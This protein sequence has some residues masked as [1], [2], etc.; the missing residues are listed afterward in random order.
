MLRV[1]AKDYIELG[2]QISAGRITFELD[3]CVEKDEHGTVKLTKIGVDTLRGDLAELLKVCDHLTLPI[4]KSLIS[5]RMSDPPRT[6]REFALLVEAVLEELKNLLFLFVPQHRA[7]YYELIL[8]S[9]VT[10]AFPVAA[11][12]IAAAGNCVAAAVY[13]ASVFHSMRA[14]EIGIQAMARALNVTF[15]YPLELAEWGKIVGEIEPKINDLKA[16]PRSTQRDEDL[17]FYSEAA[18]QFRHFNNGWRIRAAHARAMYEEHQ[19]IAVFDHTISFF[20]TL[21]IRLKE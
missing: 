15:P 2:E 21:A 1:S 12:E 5:N 13:T 10:V 9:I 11:Q 7:K 17:K 20:Q 14:V 4:S 3:D 18:S 8:P 16:G 19:A 6:E